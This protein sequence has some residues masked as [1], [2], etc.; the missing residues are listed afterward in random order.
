[1]CVY[2]CVCICVCKS[3]IYC[4]DTPWI[5]KKE[6]ENLMLQWGAMTEL[7]RTKLQDCF[8]RIVLEKSSI[9]MT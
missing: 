7:R 6:T 4:K 8:Y 9:K 1:M 5:K 3:L 2:I